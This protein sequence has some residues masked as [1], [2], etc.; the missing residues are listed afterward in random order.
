MSASGGKTDVDQPLSRF[1][2][3]GPS[4]LRR[5]ISSNWCGLNLNFGLTTDFL[6]RL[7]PQNSEEQ[8][9]LSRSGA[10]RITQIEGGRFF[11]APHRKI[12]GPSKKEEWRSP[13]YY[14]FNIT[15]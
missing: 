4:S 1:M 13:L 7:F 14:F 9:N 10:G 3:A 15:T 6:A 2:S 11:R 8:S 12:S 5:L